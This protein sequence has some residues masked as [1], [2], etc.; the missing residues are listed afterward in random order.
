VVAAVQRRARNDELR[1]FRHQGV[2]AGALRAAGRW[3]ALAPAVL[4]ALTG[5]LV[6][7]VARL[8]TRSAVPVFTDGWPNP[9]GPTGARAP[10]L[11]ACAL[12]LLVVFGL[13]ALAPQYTR[14]RRSRR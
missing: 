9:T 2:P 8:V 7:A 6:A 10:A 1:S 14:S 4:A 3:S 12:L 5:A 13:G 11:L